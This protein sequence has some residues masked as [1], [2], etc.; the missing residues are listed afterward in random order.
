MWNLKFLDKNYINHKLFENNNRNKKLFYFKS[1]I[2]FLF[3]FQTQVK[4]FETLKNYATSTHRFLKNESNVGEAS[5]DLN[6]SDFIF[7]S[8]KTLPLV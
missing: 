3:N 7:R 4:V 5:T 2:I 1:K 6:G 8:F